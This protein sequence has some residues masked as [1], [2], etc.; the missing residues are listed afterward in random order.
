MTARQ[1][2]PIP[3]P[4]EQS[5]GA[6]AREW[7]DIQQP[8]IRPVC[9][10]VLA[11]LAPVRGRTLL[12]IGCGAGGFLAL[13]HDDGAVVAGLDASVQLLEIAQR[14]IP[15][16]ALHVGDMQDLPFP[17]G[18]FDIVTAFTSLHLARDQDAAVRE[19]VRVTKPGGALVIATW[20]PPDECDAVDY[21]LELGALMPPEPI[22]RLG[23]DPSAPRT[24][25]AALARSGITPPPWRSVPCPWHYRDL[26]TALRGLLSTGPAAQAIQYALPEEVSAAVIAA[27]A[28]FR[29][30]DGSY[31][32]NN[33]CHY[34]IAHPSG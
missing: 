1:P 4:S 34:L 2:A 12:D 22:D 7:A 30:S 24:L 17:D 29:K 13:A 15:H 25:A 11:D 10:A 31:L 9:L 19:A 16:G 28:P 32:L 18:S 6:H 27:I 14:G 23:G 20:G 26:P 8:M 21:L 33:T 5:W 3:S